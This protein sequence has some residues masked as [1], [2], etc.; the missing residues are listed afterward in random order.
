MRRSRL[1]P[2]TASDKASVIAVYTARVICPMHFKWI[3]STLVY[4]QYP[5]R[6]SA[7]QLAIP[8]LSD[9]NFQQLI[10]VRTRH[11]CVHQPL[12]VVAREPPLP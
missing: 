10:L 5:V 2:P 3:I 7:R 9:V 6:K 4:L 11:H 1:T 8:R 12:P